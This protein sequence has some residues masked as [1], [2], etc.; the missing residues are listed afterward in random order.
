ML[1]N[2]S[3]KT[4]HF[5][6]SFSNII[7]IINTVN[8][9]NTVNIINTACIIHLINPQCFRTL[10]HLAYQITFLLTFIHIFI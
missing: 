3:A 7:K 1:A 6:R 9:I 5:C 2:M 10:S 4:L 8:F